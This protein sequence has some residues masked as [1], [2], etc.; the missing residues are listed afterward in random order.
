[1]EPGLQSRPLL[2]ENDTFTVLG[3][4]FLTGINGAE[5]PFPEESPVI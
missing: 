4:E 5:A 2:R 3:S 1:M